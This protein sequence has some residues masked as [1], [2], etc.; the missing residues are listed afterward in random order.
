MRAPNCAT[1]PHFGEKP[2]F[3]GNAAFHDGQTS[4]CRPPIIL[5]VTRLIYLSL[6]IA[7]S[8]LATAALLL[9]RSRS[10]WRITFDDL[11][12]AYARTLT[13]GEQRDAVTRVL[14]TLRKHRCESHGLRHRPG[15][16]RR[17]SRPARR[18]RAS[19]PCRREPQLFPSDLGATSVDS[20]TLDIQKGEE[21]IG[22]WLKGVQYFR[23]P[24]LRQGN[25]VEKRDAR[26][27]AG[28]PRAGLSSRRSRST[29]TTSSST[30]GW[31]TRRR[32]G[33][34]SRCA[35]LISIT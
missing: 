19:R 31:S 20:Y 26:P 18:S 35:S 27:S 9:G 12:F 23:Y 14:T 25:T 2:T 5:I 30:S 33:E 11:P 8:M 7:A 34:R 28:W 10:R 24:M 17:Q 16:Y 3:N 15:H 29:T 4:P 32:R 22:P 6:A 21:A 1:G 13:L